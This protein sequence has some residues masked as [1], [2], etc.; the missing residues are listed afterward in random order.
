MMFSALSLYGLHYFDLGFSPPKGVIL[1]QSSSAS[2][3]SAAC[4]RRGASLTSA[5]CRAVTIATSANAKSRS[6][7]LAMPGPTSSGSCLHA[8]TSVCFV[9]FFDDNPTKWGSDIHGIPVMGP[10]DQ[11]QRKK[12]QLA[13][14]EVVIAMPSA[15][16]RRIGE[17]VSLLQQSNGRTRQSRASAN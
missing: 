14:E 17:V 12:E 2:S 10:P 1:V 4:A 11:I 16:A 6:S 9:A 3:P 5:T 13:L 7:W 15:P 8:P